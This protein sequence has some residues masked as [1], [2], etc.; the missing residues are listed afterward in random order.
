MQIDRR[1][2]MAG[3]VATG[4][5]P[6]A[7]TIPVPARAAAPPVGKQA[8]GFYRFKV[9]D[10]EV[11][12][13][14]DG[15]VK[16]A[17]PNKFI[18]NKTPEE[19]SVALDA[20]AIPRDNMRNPF[21][22]VVVNT[23]KN[24]VLIDTGFGDNGPP[25]VGG[26]M[27]NM[28]AAGIDPKNIDTVLITHFH[29]D[30]I[31]GIRAKAGT[32]NY[33]NAEV[34]VATSEYKFWTDEGE[35]S[36]AAQ[37]WKGG[38]A[39]V[40]RVFDPIAKDVKRAEYGNEVVPGITMIDSR[41]HSPGHAS[42]LVTSGTGKLMVLGDVTNNPAIF[43]RNPEF[44]LW[45]DMIPDLALTNRRKLLDMASADKIRVVGY[46]YVFP[47]T[48]YFVKQGKGYEFAPAAWE[49]TL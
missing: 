27:G 13:L 24:L 8:P 45:A 14:F 12:T 43:A 31:S 33:P 40:K 25:G 20:A 42:Y 44:Q 26:L 3:V 49:G 36:R 34:I 18:V 48:G 41:G 22:P 30:H 46:H 38:F 39:G 1:K 17:D 4:V 29:G 5:L 9:G 16:V 23:G 7:A 19:I 37:V 47:S 35:A 15:N 2:F 28:A 10:F 11:T 32:A 6:A 21:V